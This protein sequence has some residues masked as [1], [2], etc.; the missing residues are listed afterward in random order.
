MNEKPTHT[1]RLIHE[2]SPY[3]LQH[4]HNPVDWYP[5]GP[6]ALE[7]AR[8]EDRLILLS[9]GY[10]ACHWC[11]VMERE[12]FSDEEVARALEGWVA[13]KV[14]REERPDLDELYMNAALITTGGGGWPLNVFLTPDARPFFAGTFFPKQPRAGSPGFIDVLVNIRDRYRLSPAEIGAVARE[15]TEALERT[16]RPPRAEEPELAHSERGYRQVVRYY[17]P[18]HGGFGPAPKF[19]QAMV[20]RYLLAYHR[21]TRDALA[22][23]AAELA[24]ENMARGGIFD[25]LGGG[26]HRYSVDER[27]LIPHFEKMLYD[28]GMLVPAYLEA[29]RLTGKDLYLRVARETLD[30]VLRELSG[31]EGGFLSS[32]DAETEGVEGKFWTWTLAEVER[33]LSPEE[34]EAVTTYYAISEAGNF[35]GQNVLYRPRTP[36]QAA[37]YL[38]LEPA[39]LAAR[40][41]RGRAKLMA[42]RGQRTRPGVDQKV[43]TGWNGL[44]IEALA[45][46]S[47]LS[48]EG[49]YLEAARGAARL[50][51]ERLWTDGWLKRIYINGQARID[52]FADDH[53]LLAAGLLALHR[54]DPAGGEW[55]GAA[56]RLTDELLEAFWEPASGSLLYHRREGHDLIVPVRKP[57]DSP[58][59][60]ANAW[61]ARVLLA[62]A[63]ELKEPAYRDRARAMLA[64]YTAQAAEHALFMAAT[65][66]AIEDF[67][68]A[69]EG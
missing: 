6:E 53:A 46:A 37:R 58:T 4:A 18:A 39:E 27:W 5:W 19:P 32:Q 66:L 51:L 25:Q 62:L 31:P 64:P 50:A 26:F 47:R 10:S 28:Q 35:D 12:C 17:D 36:E 54:A 69:P 56:R 29:W 49:R 24:L 15:V 42:A 55:L 14:D 59:P 34:A 41:E 1:N 7:L 11:H 9:I 44:L 48:G 22:L 20:L 8:R 21:R 23:E 2:S 45:D 57:A 38:R 16:L 43:I 65:L 63:G 61:A 3:L 60:N 30:F 40:L 52:A 68:A 67:Y 33:L 13:I